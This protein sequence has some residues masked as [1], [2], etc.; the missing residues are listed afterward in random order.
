M[1]FLPASLV[2]RVSLVLWPPTSAASVPPRCTTAV[3]LPV[4]L[5]LQIYPSFPFWHVSPTPV[6]LSS[7]VI[8]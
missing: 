6:S 1:A 3:R 8:L 5:T 4:A 7:D 2:C